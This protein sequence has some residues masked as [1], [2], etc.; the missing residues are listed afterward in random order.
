MTEGEPHISIPAYLWAV[1]LTILNAALGLLLASWRREMNDV[2]K[3]AEEARD[4]LGRHKL[5]AAETFA[6]KSEVREAVEQLGE[7]FDKTDTKLDAIRDRLPPKT[8]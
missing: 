1:L 4:G 2:K 3:I 5:H 8:H 6:T 7:R